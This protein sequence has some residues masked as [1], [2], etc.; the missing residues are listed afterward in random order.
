MIGLTI[1]LGILCIAFA[2]AIA[3]QDGKNAKLTADNALMK[4]RV[5]EM[6]KAVASRPAADDK[7]AGFLLYSG[8]T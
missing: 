4:G 2:I 5:E 7:S 6:E 3:T 1:T 8:K